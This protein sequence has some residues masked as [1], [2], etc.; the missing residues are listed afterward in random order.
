MIF[1]DVQ[2]GEVKARLFLAADLNDRFKSWGFRAK[3]SVL[4]FQ[5]R[6]D[7]EDLRLLAEFPQFLTSPLLPDAFQEACAHLAPKHLQAFPFNL[8][9]C[10]GCCLLS[11]VR[12][13]QSSSRKKMGSSMKQGQ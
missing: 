5:S 8:P 13:N 1:P 4:I 11:G 7:A 6:N 10:N 9:G 3:R 12:E 2:I